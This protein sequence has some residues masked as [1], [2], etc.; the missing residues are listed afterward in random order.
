MVLKGLFSVGESP[1]SLYESNI[2][3]AKAAF[4]VV[5]CHVIPHVCAD[6][7]PFDR[8]CDWCSGDLLWILS[9]A[10]SLPC[11]YRSLAV[12]AM[13]SVQS[14]ASSPHMSACKDCS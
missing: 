14:P 10:P 3:G 9:G 8:V 12:G 2:F 6:H 1:C 13:K 7:Y 11:G 5:A 4:S